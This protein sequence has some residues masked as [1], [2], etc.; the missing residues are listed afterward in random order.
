MNKIYWLG[1]LLCATISVSAESVSSVTFNPSRLGDYE[2]LK[3]SGS[4]TLRGGLKAKD[5][6]L[7][8]K[9]TATAVQQNGSANPANET[10][11]VISLFF[12]GTLSSNL[13][14]FVLDSV[15]GD[16]TR[17]FINMPSAIFHKKG[18][19]AVSNFSHSS[20]TPSTTDYGTNITMS[21]GT[22]TFNGGTG[23]D[24]SDSIIG[25]L[26]GNDNLLQY[27]NRVDVGTL[28]VSGSPDNGVTLMGSLDSNGVENDAGSTRLFRLGGVDIP[29]PDADS[30]R[31]RKA[32]SEATASAYPATFED[33]EGDSMSSCQL[34]WVKR[35]LT[36][37]TE[38][39]P[40]DLN[41][42]V[43]ALAG[44]CPLACVPSEKTSDY[45]YDACPNGQYGRKKRL[46][47]R[48]I[49]CTNGQEEERITYPNGDTWD[50]SDCKNNPQWTYVENSAEPNTYQSHWAWTDNGYN[51]MYWNIFCWCWK[52][53]FHVTGINETKCY[54]NNSTRLIFGDTV[55]PLSNYVELVVQLGLTTLA[56]PVP[57]L[58]DDI[59]DLQFD[60]TG[61][62][63][64]RLWR[65]RVGGDHSHK[66]RN[67]DIA[68]NAPTCTVALANST[69]E[70][71]KTVWEEIYFLRPR[72]TGVWPV[73]CN[74]WG[75]RVKYRCQ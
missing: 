54:V 43:L 52:K 47:Y 63:F 22:L 14:M 19:N 42:Y 25:T 62:T 10:T 28:T 34:H 27:A 45:E 30:V 21:G 61:L 1:V 72:I 6:N 29:Y 31:H 73:T 2:H 5:L 16:S 70:A 68:Q 23:T 60:T 35:K 8:V 13:D 4:A 37:Q 17:P 49:V 57:S 58:W 24:T 11:G 7:G 9:P 53:A 71:A 69:N 48:Q 67:G 39:S 44:N 55:A 32:G 51:E 40:A 26:K 50:T 46:F 74:G 38:Q 56:L 59:W 15:S 3:V 36:P 64:K 33:F 66:W 41:V 20:T 18:A 65:N 75:Y 12:P